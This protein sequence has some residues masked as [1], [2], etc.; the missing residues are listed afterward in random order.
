METMKRK[1]RHFSVRLFVI[2]EKCALE[3]EV[4]LSKDLMV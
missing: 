2:M 3:D 1:K 4:I